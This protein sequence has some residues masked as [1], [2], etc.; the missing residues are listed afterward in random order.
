MI[1]FRDLRHRGGVRGIAEVHPTTERA[2][3]AQVA[4]ALLPER[5]ELRARIRNRCP[6]VRA[7]VIDLEAGGEQHVTGRRKVAAAARKTAGRAARRELGLELLVDRF[8]LAEGRVSRGAA[9]RR[10]RGGDAFEGPG[11]S[12]PESK[13]IVRLPSI[14][15]SMSEISSPMS[16]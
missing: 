15:V 8:A 4:A 2:A 13:S 12:P 6:A 1:T 10:R 14:C 11:S 5:T 7:R 3:F 16:V 9:H